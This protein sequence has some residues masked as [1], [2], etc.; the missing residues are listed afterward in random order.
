MKVFCHASTTTSLCYL[1]KHHNQ[2]REKI[3]TY[4]QTQPFNE[5]P[6]N[7][8]LKNPVWERTDLVSLGI[9]PGILHLSHLYPVIVVLI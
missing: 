3:S 5:T 1:K 2:C 8:S 4:E 9:P 7:I 6:S